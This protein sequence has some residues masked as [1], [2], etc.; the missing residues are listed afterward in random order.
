MFPGLYKAP[1]DPCMDKPNRWLLVC[2][3]QGFS[4]SLVS[5]SKKM[6]WLPKLQDSFINPTFWRFTL[7][8]ASVVLASVFYAGLQQHPSGSAFEQVHSLP[9]YS[10]GGLRGPT[11]QVPGAH[12]EPASAGAVPPLNGCGSRG[13]P[14]ATYPR[15]TLFNSHPL[16][17]R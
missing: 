3:A 7:I 11:L 13:R 14:A 4:D 12:A 15:G 1:T 16:A 5:I 17:R 2:T 8:P 9:R 6:K 10:C